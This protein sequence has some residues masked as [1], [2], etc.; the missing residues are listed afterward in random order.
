M[1]RGGIC[2]IDSSS[3]GFGFTLDIYEINLENSSYMRY[4]YVH[5]S[6]LFDHLKYEYELFILIKIWSHKICK[7]SNKMLNQL[8][9][10]YILYTQIKT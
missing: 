9:L 3:V 2:E 8:S 7:S 1:S 10:I 4:I 6:D 5:I